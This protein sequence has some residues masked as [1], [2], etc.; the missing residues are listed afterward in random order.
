MVSGYGYGG[1]GYKYA[2]YG[3]EVGVRG[4]REAADTAFVAIARVGLID[5]T[6]CWGVDFSALL[7]ENGV[8]GVACTVSWMLKPWGAAAQ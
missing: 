8:L 2:G 7:R 4:A 3:Y 1:P 6:C 5:T